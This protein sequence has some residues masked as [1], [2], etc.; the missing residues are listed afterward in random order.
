LPL[1]TIPIDIKPAIAT[2][3]SAIRKELEN[4]TGDRPARD[5]D[6]VA[7][8][9]TSGRPACINSFLMEFSRARDHSCLR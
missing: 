4:K 9:R 3:A 2:L 5:L 8:A 7:A 6:A 1:Y